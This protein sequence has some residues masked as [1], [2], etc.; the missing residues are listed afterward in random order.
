LQ[1]G[2]H[3]KLIWRIPRIVATQRIHAQKTPN[4]RIVDPKAVVINV[5]RA[6]LIVFIQLFAIEAIA[7]A[8]SAAHRTIRRAKGEI[9]RRIRDHWVENW[10]A[11]LAAILDHPFLANLLDVF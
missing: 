10:A 11:E 4:A 6:K 8:R 3:Q 5:G 9:I 7:I 2:Y 1:L